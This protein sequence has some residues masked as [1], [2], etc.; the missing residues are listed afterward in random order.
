MW[1]HCTNTAARCGSL[2][3]VLRRCVCWCNCIMDEFNQNKCL[4]AVKI[5]SVLTS[6]ITS[7]AEMTC[8]LM[9]LHGE[10]TQSEN[11]LIMIKTDSV[12]AACTAPYVEMMC[13]SVSLHHRSIQLEKC[14]VVT[15]ADSVLTVLCWRSMMVSTLT[16][17]HAE[18]I[19]MYQ[20]DWVSW[21]HL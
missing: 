6:H 1:L 17:V 14:L 3:C 8:A 9:W 15:E 13:V 19:N 5:I 7:C 16:A 2:C 18:C 4:I 21:F 11:W 10:C 12:F 20:I